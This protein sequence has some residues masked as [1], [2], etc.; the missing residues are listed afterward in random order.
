MRSL[1]DL[2]RVAPALL[3]HRSATVRPVD[4]AALHTELGVALP[5]DYRAF[6]DHYPPL[7]IDDALILR[8]PEP[9]AESAYVSGVF[10]LSEEV[11]GWSE[12]YPVHPAEDGLICWGGTDTGDYFFWRRNGPDP[13]RWPAVVWTSR[14]L[15]WEHEGGFLSLLVGLIDGSVEHRGLTPQPGPNPSITPTV[16][17]P[18][19]RG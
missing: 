1:S 17:A 7:W 10:S 8:V 14:D 2:E 6:A 3:P 16:R 5:A 18:E 13:G 19:G 15:W 4:W 9:G 11:D 12:D